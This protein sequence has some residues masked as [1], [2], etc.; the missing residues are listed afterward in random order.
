MSSGGV[1]KP[2]LSAGI[3]AAASVMSLLR[4]ARVFRRNVETRL[5]PRLTTGGLFRAKT[6]G[7]HRPAKTRIKPRFFMCA[8]G[9]RS[10]GRAATERTEQ[11]GIR[12]PL[13]APT[14]QGRSALPPEQS[15]AGPPNTRR[16]A[17]GFDQSL[18]L[19]VRSL[20]PSHNMLRRTNPTSTAIRCRSYRIDPGHLAF[21]GLRDGFGRPRSRSTTRSLRVPSRCLFQPTL[22]PS[23]RFG[24][25]TPI[26]LPSATDTAFECVG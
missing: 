18:R 3:S 11:G 14:G 5:F 9:N 10:L 8:Q 15:S 16:A 13:P 4:C 24:P 6:G 2:Y 23:R 21:L 25:H 22:R 20:D 12:N 17:S 26:P 1:L 7:H 19:E